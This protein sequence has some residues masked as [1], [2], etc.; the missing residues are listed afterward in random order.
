MSL[1]AVRTGATKC[2]PAETLLL[3]VTNPM[4]TSNS[5]TSANFAIRLI[6]PSFA[7]IMN[8]FRLRRAFLQCCGVRLSGQSETRSPVSGAYPRLSRKGCQRIHNV[9]SGSV[10][11]YAT[12][13]D[14]GSVTAK[15]NA[16][17]EAGLRLLRRC[18]AA[19]Q[20]S[21]HRVTSENRK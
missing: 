19:R 6:R 13:Q 17:H 11:G 1:A 8:G 5:A 18:G 10:S 3:V 14:L 2:E 12:Y 21:C 7:A 15:A 9:G 4:Q 16:N 20:A